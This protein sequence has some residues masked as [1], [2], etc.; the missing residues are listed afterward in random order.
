[1]NELVSKELNCIN[2]P[3]NTTAQNR[4]QDFPLAH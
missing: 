1:M 3:N 2:E 4:N